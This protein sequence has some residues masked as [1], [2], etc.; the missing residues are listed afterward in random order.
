M[1]VLTA[2]VLLLGAAGVV[3]AARTLR[4]RGAELR[5]VHDGARVVG[6]PGYRL[7][8]SRTST[9]LARLAEA[10]DTAHLRTLDAVARKADADRRHRREVTRAGRDLRVRLDTLR[11]AVFA[12]TAAAADGP[13]PAPAPCGYERVAAAAADLAGLVDVLLEASCRSLD[14]GA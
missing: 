12:V 10:L 6:Q 11:A 2:A 9:E 8:R 13:A 3:V 1:N 7:L 14:S 5:L 4:R